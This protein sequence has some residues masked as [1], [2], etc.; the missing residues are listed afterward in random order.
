MILHDIYRKLIPQNIRKKVY[1]IYESY[2]NYKSRYSF[3]KCQFKINKFG[4]ENPKKTF[5]VIKDSNPYAGLLSEYFAF[6][7]VINYAE[8]HNFIPII[9]LKNYYMDTICDKEN[10]GKINAWD[11]YFEQPCK[12]YSLENVYQSKHVIICPTVWSPELKEYHVRKGNNENLIELSD[13]QKQNFSFFYNKCPLRNE[14]LKHAQFLYNTLF[15]KNERVLGVSF[16]RAYERHHYWKDPITPDGTHLVHYTLKTIIPKIKEIMRNDN[17]KYFFL[18]C[19]DRE[20]NDEIKNEFNEKCIIFERPLPHYFINN[21]PIPVDYK[22]DY[23]II[24]QEFS[25]DNNGV[26]NRNIDYLSAIV[27]L[28]NCNSILNAGGTADVF[29]SILNNWSYE[30]IYS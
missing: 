20:A 9:D 8:L 29:A 26:T 25:N 6:M 30:K 18:V 21:N 7:S 24:F 23:N 10:I 1:K 19:D 5:F 2:I 12:E 13:I 17:Y 14:I 22:D 28:S 4:K 16:R 11:F 15:P 3:I 27:L